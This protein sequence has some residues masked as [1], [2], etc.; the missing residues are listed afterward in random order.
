MGLEAGWNCHICLRSEH[1]TDVVPC[2]DVSQGYA[3]MFGSMKIDLAGTSRQNSVESDRQAESGCSPCRRFRC[4]SA[5]GLILIQSA[6]EPQRRSISTEKRHSDDLGACGWDITEED[7]ADQ[8][9]S[10]LTKFDAPLRHR[11]MSERSVSMHEPRRRSSSVRSANIKDALGR[12]TIAG[13]HADMVLELEDER[14]RAAAVLPEDM[15]VEKLNV[16]DNVDV[17]DESDGSYVLSRRSSYTDSLPPGLGNRVCV[18]YIIIIIISY[19]A[20]Y[21]TYTLLVFCSCCMY[22]VSQKAS[23]CQTPVHVFA[24][25]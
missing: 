6:N 17:D 21:V 4:N 1:S 16:D 24:R 7:M 23:S 13:R 9:L 22:T 20:V 19:E 14:K 5:P 18:Y 11:Q 15:V 12:F 2:T 10:L 3:S 25:Y 8:Q